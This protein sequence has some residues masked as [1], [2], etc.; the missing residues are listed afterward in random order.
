MVEQAEKRAGQKKHMKEKLAL[1]SGS[2]SEFERQSKKHR[3]RAKRA[4]VSESDDGEGSLSEAELD[5]DNESVDGDKIAQTFDE[6]LDDFVGVFG[7]K[8]AAPNEAQEQKSTN[9]NTQRANSA[10]MPSDK[11]EDQKQ[12]EAAAAVAAAAAMSSTVEDAIAN[13]ASPPKAGKK[14]KSDELAN[15]TGY[16]L[17]S[18]EVKENGTV[19]KTL[20][21]K[22]KQKECSQLWQAQ[23]Q[24]TKAKYA[25]LATK[26]NKQR[27]ELRI[28]RGDDPNAPKKPK[29]PKKAK[30]SSAPLEHSTAHAISVGDH[31]QQQQ[32]QQQQAAQLH[33]Q[34]PLP[35]QHQHQHQRQHASSYSQPQSAGG[36]SLPRI[37]SPYELFKEFVWAEFRDNRNH[38]QMT[39]Q[40]L[41]VMIHNQWESPYFPSHQKQF[42][43]DMS[44]RLRKQVLQEYFSDPVGVSLVPDTPIPVFK[45]IFR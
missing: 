40:Q 1:S 26:I 19:D 32:Q 25:T 30:A 5:L 43:N 31:Q 12:Q 21:S 14:R 34:L 13:I 41:G 22:E 23:T 6:E 24:E 44:D 28:L 16:I 9:D 17:F 36:S 3:K 8:V 18:Q 7:E 38:V 33:L 35:F 42:Y 11:I 29:K 37:P 2:D 4:K 39:D 10:D 27:A 15:V 20:T 45:P